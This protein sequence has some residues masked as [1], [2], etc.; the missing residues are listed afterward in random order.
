[1]HPGNTSIVA[2]DSMPAVTTASSLELA[3]QH[4]FKEATLSLWI[5]DQLALTRPLHGGSQIRL[6]V[7]KSIHGHASETVQLPPGTHVL[8]L[9]ALSSDQSVDLSKTISATFVSGDDKTLH[10]SF[11]KHNTKMQLSLD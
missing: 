9:R 2:A 3:V 7:F 6:V 5:D 8:R 11:D 1:M 10:V 4:Q